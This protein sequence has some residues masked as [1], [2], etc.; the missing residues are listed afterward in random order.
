MFH[1]PLLR[2]AVELAARLYVFL[3]INIYGLGKMANGQFHRRGH[4]PADLAQTPLTEV[5]SFDLAWTFF[6]YSR[7]YVL[8]IGLSQVVGGFL[9]LWQRTKLLGVAMLIPILL[10]IIVVDISFSVPSGAMWSAMVYL[11]L[12]LLVLYLNREKVAAA[13]VA[14][15]ARPA[16]RGI[17]GWKQQL[18]LL[19]VAGVLIGLFF[20]VEVFGIRRLG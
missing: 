18:L 12:L 8:F 1:Q 6:G 5:G 19:G 11:I 7:A 3:F 13:F 4:L 10:N 15:T 9:L 14:L 17:E 2:R 20:W 16:R